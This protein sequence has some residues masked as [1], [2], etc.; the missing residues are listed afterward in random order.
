VSLEAN[1]KVVSEGCDFNND[2]F[3]PMD[4][5]C[6]GFNW[7]ANV[8]ANTL[9]GG[10]KLVAQGCDFKSPDFNARDFAVHGWNWEASVKLTEQN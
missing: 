6:H 2:D 4:F 7:E 3:D 8:K 10:V 5:E 1:V 9:S